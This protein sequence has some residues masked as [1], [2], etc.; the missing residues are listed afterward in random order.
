M[1]RPILA[2]GFAAMC[3]AWPAPADAQE[4]FLAC[5]TSSVQ[6][7]G[8]PDTGYNKAV[9]GKPGVTRTLLQ[10]SV[11]IRCDETTLFADEVESTSDDDIVHARGNVLLVQPGMRIYAERADLNKKLRLGTFHEA[12][13]Y[14]RLTDTPSERSLFGALEADAFFWGERVEKTG[15]RTYRLTHGGFTTCVQPTPRWDIASSVGTVTLQKHAILRNAVLRVK[16]VPLLYVPVIY[17]PISKDDRSSGFLL[18]SYGSSTVRGFTLS[19]AFFWAISRSQ[20]ATFYHDWFSKTGQGFATEYRYVASPGS[21]GNM[22]VYLIDE[23]ESLAADGTVSRPAHRSYDVRGDVNQGLPH[24]FRVIGRSNYFTDALTQQLYQQ[25]PY[26]FSQRNR[27][28]SASLSGG[29]GRYRVGLTAEQTDTYY[30]LTSAQR[31]G[32]APVV[33]FDIGEKAIG[34]SLVYVGARTEAG[35]FLRQD[36]VTKP[37]TNRN[38]GRVDF[39]PTIRVPVSTLPFLT[40]TTAAKWEYT[41][42]SESLDPLSGAQVANPIT[43]QLL[44]LQLQL[45]GPTFSRIF[46]TPASHYAERFKHLIEP[47]LT[48]HWFSPFADFDRV[49]K[50]AS[51]GIDYVFGGTTQFDYTLTNRVFAKRKTPGRTAA[52]SI[53]TVRVAQSYY[54]DSRA[55]SFD[56]QYQ[57][58]FGPT[59]NVFVPSPFSPVR[60]TVEAQPFDAI[61]GRFGLEYDARFHAIRTH[62]ATGGVNLQSVRLSAGWSKR[63]FVPGLPNFDNKDFASQSLTANATVSTRDKRLGG[64]F[65]FNYDLHNRSFVQKRLVAYYNTQCCG[66]ALDYQT[67]GLAAF[68]TAFKGDRR[69][70]ISFT[71]AG[72]GSFS[73]PMGSFGNNSGSR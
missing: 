58:S 44:D 11:V 53:L 18:P 28:V 13:G 15:A 64:T 21:T 38:L 57:S 2:S 37:E 71:L 72:I 63:Y 14:V 65:G 36:D 39:A 59:S 31:L 5:A 1:F 12:T 73:N 61:D 51:D 17:Y 42:W 24:G 55:S 49:S 66:I 60:L 56:Q 52:A 33:S 16:G 25:N 40:V 10:D 50:A 29:F 70:G 3:L 67:V 7:K 30:G 45:V 43:R 32:R 35:Y 69:F 19:N 34:H 4:A 62:T 23:H 46:Q 41:F 8:G 54:T 47:S 26:D 6:Y 68:G 48:V 22:R 20:D 9:E 27:T